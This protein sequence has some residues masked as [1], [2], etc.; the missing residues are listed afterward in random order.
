MNKTILAGALLAAIGGSF[1]LSI[2]SAQALR[3]LPPSPHP[4]AGFG[5][6]T[7]ANSGPQHAKPPKTCPTWSMGCV[8]FP[9]R[10]KDR[11][12]K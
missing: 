2:G 10:K 5:I 12:R 4:S 11:P 8:L 9:E 6:T 3:P 1:A 7:K